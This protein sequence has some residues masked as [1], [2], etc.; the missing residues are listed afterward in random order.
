[1]TKRDQTKFFDKRGF[2][3]QRES[4]HF[5]WRHRKLGLKVVTAKTPSTKNFEKQI[6]KHIKQAFH[7]HETV[8]LKRVA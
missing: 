3:L 8:L 6:T 1:M 4:N 7:Y 5:V 2:D